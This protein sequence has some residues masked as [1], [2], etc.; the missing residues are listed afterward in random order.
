MVAQLA[1]LGL[2]ADNTANVMGRSLS[3]YEPPAAHLDGYEIR[4]VSTSEDLAGGMA[5]LGEDWFDVKERRQR[6]RIYEAIGLGEMS[7]AR[8]WVARGDG[9]VIALATLFRFDDVVELAQCGVA[10]AHRRRGIARALT[11]TRLRAAIGDGASAAVLSPSQDG[12]LLHRQLG[13]TLLPTLRD[14]WFHVAATA[15]DQPP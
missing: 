15:V 14:R 12:Y 2:R 11:G 1:A 4:E 9:R 5:A 3:A 6:L 8:H 10:A 7:R 13:F